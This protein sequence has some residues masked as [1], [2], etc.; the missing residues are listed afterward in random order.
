MAGLITEG[1]K[2]Y[3]AKAKEFFIG[4]GLV[5]VGAFIAIGG[6]LLHND[7]AFWGSFIPMVTGCG[8]IIDSI[9]IDPRPKK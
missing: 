5:A 2:R 6:Y 7:L 8:L 3:N 4:L 9:F 1:E